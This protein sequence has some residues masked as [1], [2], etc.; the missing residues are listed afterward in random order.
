MNYEHLQLGYELKSLKEFMETKGVTFCVTGTLA[1]Q[2]IGAVPPEHSVKDID[3]IALSD[4]GVE[5]EKWSSM[6]NNLDQLAGGAHNRLMKENHYK[7]PPFVFGVGNRGV[8]INV[9]VTKN[10]PEE[11]MIK[12]A[13]ESDSYLVHTFRTAMHYKMHLMRQK[14]FIFQ[15]RLIRYIT[16]IGNREIY[17]LGAAPIIR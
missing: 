15:A 17:N 4:V 5:R 1:L 3:V 13:V 6:F 7:N 16:Q 8:K 9:W 10:Q 2:M 14:D 12:V 11:D